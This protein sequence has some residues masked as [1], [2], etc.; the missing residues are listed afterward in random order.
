MWNA[1]AIL[2]SALFVLVGYLP[3]QA[4]VRDLALTIH[5]HPSL[6]EGLM[7]AALVAL[8]EAVHVMPR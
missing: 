8:G 6:S 3:A 1:P 2:L 7:E 4:Q 5:P